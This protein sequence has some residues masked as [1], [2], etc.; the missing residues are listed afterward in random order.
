MNLKTLP[1]PLPMLDTSYY[2]GRHQ[3]SGEWQYVPIDWSEAKSKWQAV[4]IKE[5][6][7]LNVDPLFEAQFRAAEGQVLRG[8][9]HF[10]DPDVNAI[11][12]AHSCADA[13]EHAGGYGE[14]GV[15]LDIEI[16]PS[17]LDGETYLRN[18]GSWLYEMGNSLAK[19]GADVPLC[20][21]TR[22]SFWDPLFFQAKS[23]RWVA[24]YPVWVAIYPY[25]KLP[26]FA[27]WYATLLSGNHLPDRPGLP[28]GFTTL[29]AWQWTARGKPPDIPGYPPYK[30][31]VDLNLLYCQPTAEP[32]EPGGGELPASEAAIRLDEL[33]RL[34]AAMK[35]YFDQ[36]RQELT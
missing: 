16:N 31:S 15:F 10:F 28:R 20:I 11:K 8:L 36:R 33:A 35:Q 32:Q 12:S 25:D 6:Q 4:I 5:G 21:Y 27:N 34:E 26:D 19:F 17:K 18:V 3:V 29:Y 23:P 24:K 22:A 30:K 2:D 9:Y 14:L 1:A 13:A 7:G